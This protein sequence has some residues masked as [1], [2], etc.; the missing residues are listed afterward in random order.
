MNP[1]TATRRRKHRPTPALTGPLYPQQLLYCHRIK[2]RY[3]PASWLINLL[4]WLVGISQ[5]FR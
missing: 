2:R 1:Q 5:P 3:I 4:H